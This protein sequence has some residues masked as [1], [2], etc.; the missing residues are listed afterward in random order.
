M[1]LWSVEF[2]IEDHERIPLDY[3]GVRVV[4][5]H[6]YYVVRPWEEGTGPSSINLEVNTDSV[7]EAKEQAIAL[8]AQIRK[9]AGLSP[10]PPRI[11]TIAQVVGVPFPAD[12]LVFEA[13]DMYEQRRFGL[14][15]VAAQVH[16]EMWIRAKIEEIANASGNALVQLDG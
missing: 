5:P 8:Y 9:E 1:P 11:A 14:A 16:C 6:S 10:D 3:A 4:G 15:V 7:E 12:R 13:E 2:V